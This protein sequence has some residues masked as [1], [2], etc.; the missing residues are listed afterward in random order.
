[1][2]NCA[3]MRT[4][5]H[6]GFATERFSSFNDGSW[7]EVNELPTCRFIFDPDAE[8]CAC[9]PNHHAAALRACVLA[10]IVQ[11]F[12]DELQHFCG[13]TVA[14]VEL[15]FHSQCDFN[16]MHLLDLFCLPLQ[17]GKE[18][19]FD[20][21]CLVPQSSGVVPQLC[22]D[23][24]CHGRLPIEVFDQGVICGCLVANGIEA[25][26]EADVGLDRRI[27]QVPC[28]LLTLAAGCI[29]RHAVEKLDVF[30]N[31]KCLFHKMSKEQGVGPVESASRRHHIHAAFRLSHLQRCADEAVAFQ[32]FCHAAAALGV[33]QCPFFQRA[34]M[35]H[36]FGLQPKD[37]P[38]EAGIHI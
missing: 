21:A 1:M 5:H 6:T 3:A 14:Y 31:R 36:A 19:R 32:Q 27:M 25:K 30:D 28:D 33:M 15:A 29:R 37:W 17:I 7:L 22:V 8:R 20:V 26:F 2:H 12:S 11:A 10:D 9:T 34:V 16:A 13:Q 24:R 23:L 4:L 18:C 38:T 35:Y